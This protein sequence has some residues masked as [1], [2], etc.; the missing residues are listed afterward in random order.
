MDTEMG[1]G[2]SGNLT[3]RLKEAATVTLPTS[4]LSALHRAARIAVASEL[5]LL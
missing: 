4:L 2:A 5:P 1:S 3:K